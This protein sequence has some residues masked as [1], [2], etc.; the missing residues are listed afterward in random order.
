MEVTASKLPD[1]YLIHIFPEC[2]LGQA[3]PATSEE[4]NEW[5]LGV[6]QAPRPCPHCK[7]VDLEIREVVERRDGRIEVEG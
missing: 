3:V 2:R 6:P 5:R 7:T 4:V 1:R